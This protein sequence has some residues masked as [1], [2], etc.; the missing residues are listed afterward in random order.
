MFIAN[1]SQ[2]RQTMQKITDFLV[3]IKETFA[4][5]RYATSSR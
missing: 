3:A 2:R 4:A 1:I 5:R